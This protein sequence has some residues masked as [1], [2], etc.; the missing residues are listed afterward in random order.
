[1][2]DEPIS[3]AITFTYEADK[4]GCGTAF[5]SDEVNEATM[6]ASHVGNDP[7]GNPLLIL[8]HA[9]LH[10]INYDDESRCRWA[11]EPGE[12]RWIFTR[13]G[14]FLRVT[15][16][17]FNTLGP[18]FYGSTLKDEFGELGFSMTCD[19]WK[20][21]AKVRLACSRIIASETSKGASHWLRDS[22]EY[23]GLC[24]VIEKHKHNEV[25]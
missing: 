25:Q 14:D 24:T 5:I 18:W 6:W 19:L 3:T 22:S 12:T 20:F 11:N 7:P 1:M 4:W 21:A 16:L 15:I 17:W 9:L 13:E 23:H 10:V 8:V 2:P